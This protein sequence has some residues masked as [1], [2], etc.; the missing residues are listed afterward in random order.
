[1]GTSFIGN[2]LNR[3]FERIEKSLFLRRFIT[4]AIM[5]NPPEFPRP[6]RSILIKGLPLPLSNSHLEKSNNQSLTLNSNKFK[7]GKFPPSFFKRKA[8]MDYI[9][10]SYKGALEAILRIPLKPYFDSSPGSLLRTHSSV[11][12]FWES[13]NMLSKM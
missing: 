9:F 13:G 11:Q 4:K 3:H 12:A 5:R 6:N 10:S 7:R 1:M 2:P 8:G